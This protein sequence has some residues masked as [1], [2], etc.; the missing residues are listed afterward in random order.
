MFVV[1]CLWFAVIGLFFGCLLTCCGICLRVVCCA[2]FVVFAVLGASWLLFV[3]GSLLVVVCSCCCWLLCGV[4]WLGV[5]GWLRAARCITCL[6]LVACCLSAVVCRVLSDE[7]RALF[8]VCSSLRVVRCV[9]F[10]VCGL[11]IVVYCSVFVGC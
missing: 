2:L 6:L 5:H 9:V 11:L 3:G 1:C 4:C 8:A 7:R 10:V